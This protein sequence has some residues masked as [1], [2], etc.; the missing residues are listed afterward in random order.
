MN[1]G[2]ETGHWCPEAGCGGGRRRWRAKA[3]SRW[4]ASGRAEA[5]ALLLPDYG[6]RT[7][8]EDGSRRRRS[9]V[10]TR[11]AKDGNLCHTGDLVT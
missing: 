9:Q 5:G 7:M 6:P 11:Q 2:A 1:A 4:R 8:A 3:G 10:T